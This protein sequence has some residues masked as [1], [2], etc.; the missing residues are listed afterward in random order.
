MLRPLLGNENS[1]ARYIEYVNT[2]YTLIRKEPKL[3]GFEVHAICVHP[4][5]LFGL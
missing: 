4:L 3:E 1:I 2:C 5:S